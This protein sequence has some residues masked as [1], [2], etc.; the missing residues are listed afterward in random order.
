M[1]QTCGLSSKKMESTIIYEDNIALFYWNG[2]I[3]IQKIC[4]CENLTSLFT[5]Q[6]E[7]LSNG[8]Q[9]LILPF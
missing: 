6:R 8:S 9:D 5:N 3:K 1:R 4:S 7:L 2:D